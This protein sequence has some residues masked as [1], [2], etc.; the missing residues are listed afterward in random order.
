MP[1]RR[2]P[3]LPLEGWTV[4]SLRPRGQHGGLRAAA[5]RSGARV[6]ALSTVAIEPIG[7]GA[8]RAALRE[9]MQ[10][11]LLLFTSPNAVRQ[12]NALEA[13]SARRGQCVLAIGSGTRS[14][15]ERL[16]IDASSPARMD[17]EGLLAMPALQSVAGR[18]IALVSGAGGRN[19]LAPALRERGAQVTRVDTYRRR[20]VALPA[21]TLGAL[22]AVLDRPD[23]VLVALS[24]AEALAALLAQLPA[25]LQ[26]ALARSA[27]AAASQRLAGVALESGF[28]RIAIAPGARPAALLCAAADAFV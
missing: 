2:R 13:L 19:L 20:P 21:R 9:A 23:R 7:D 5:A 18:R 11:E 3:A 12:A 16:G 8:V 22:A 10:A 27:V 24:S 1:A 4:L 14:A 25:A 28:H 26:P 15:L 6:L 17:S